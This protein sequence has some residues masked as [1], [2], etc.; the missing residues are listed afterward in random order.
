MNKGSDEY[1]KV[2]IPAAAK[3]AGVILLA[4]LALLILMLFFLNLVDS[5]PTF[6][7]AMDN[8][9][10]V[11]FLALFVFL[12]WL[13]NDRKAFVKKNWWL[14]L[15]AIPISWLSTSGDTA[16]VVVDIFAA[17]RF[18]VRILLLTRISRRLIPKTYALV[19]ATSLASTVLISSALFYAA[20][21][22]VNPEVNTYF[23]SFWWA[24]VSG[25]TVGYGDIAP[26][27]TA[28]RWVAILLMIFGLGVF[29]FVTGTV[30]SILSRRAK[31]FASRN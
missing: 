9:V 16:S 2:N 22:E 11:L 14:L 24:M 7:A 19:I 15:G 21:H 10:S 28:G 30:A 17:S 18:L 1:R 8:L 3:M 6:I 12:F 26:V 23:D 27:T 31:K 20:E 29:G 25:T 5:E 4:L 13:S